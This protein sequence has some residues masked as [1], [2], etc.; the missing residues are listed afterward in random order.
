MGTPSF[1]PGALRPDGL[2]GAYSVTAHGPTGR[3]KQPQTVTGTGEDE[4]G[5]VRALDARLRGQADAGLGMVERRRRLRL[6]Y[7]EGAEEWSRD[8]VGRGLT[9][10]E[11]EGV[12]RRYGGR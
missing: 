4:T 8:N 3:Y 9:G 7:V 11:L 2:P 12:L 6:A 1:D 5:A 10:D